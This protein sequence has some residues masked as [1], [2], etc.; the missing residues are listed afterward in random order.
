MKKCILI[1]FCT[2]TAWVSGTEY[3]VESV[4]NPVKA[5]AHS[6]VSNPDGILR[7]ET[8]YQINQVIDSLK[9]QTGI[10]AAVVVLNSIGKADY[11]HFAT[12]LFELWGIGKA[13]TDNGFLILLVLDQRKVKIENG[14]G[15]EGVLTDAISTRIRL[16][17]MTPEFKKGNYD[18]GLLAGVQQISAILRNEPIE[19]EKAEPIAWSEIIPLAIAAYIMLIITTLTWTINSAKKIRSNPKITTNIGRYKALKSESTGITSLFALVL[20]VV[21]VVAI[22]FLWKPVFL[23]LLIPVPFT[24]IPANI[25]AKIRMWKMRREPIPCNVCDG[26]MHLL[27]EKQED[28]HLKLAQQFEEQLHAVDYDVFRC[29][30]CENTAIFT[31]DKPSAYTECPKCGTKAFIL[32]ER[33]TLVAP[34]YISSGTE[35][36]TY[37]CRFCGHEENH[38]DN[39]PRLNRTNSAVIGGAV[40]GGIFGRGG[41]FGGGGG[42]FGGGLSGGGG[43]GGGW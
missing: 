33:R 32:K 13:K 24:S 5:N 21:G 30:K 35:R 19:Q 25:Y 37:H 10:E 28:A 2:I 36:T 43:S 8:V 42:S 23:L 14:Y 29:N 39:I 4:P 12:E 9:S 7:N 6:F 16:N 20:P 38:N 15:L 26:T 41:N 34:T 40:A 11:L 27:S 3:T 17:T 22:L 31:L 1:L 18:A